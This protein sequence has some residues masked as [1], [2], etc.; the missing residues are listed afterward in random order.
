LAQQEFLEGSGSTHTHT[1]C[2]YRYDN[3]YDCIHR[4]FL[5]ELPSLAELGNPWNILYPVWIAKT[6]TQRAGSV[7]EELFCTEKSAA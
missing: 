5:S 6:T 4:D 1:Y 3:D 2:Y 7:R